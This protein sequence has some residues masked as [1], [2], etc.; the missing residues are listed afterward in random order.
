MRTAALILA[1][2]LLAAAPA[3]AQNAAQPER[4]VPQT[5][6]NSGGP[7]GRMTAPDGSASTG[8]VGR[9]A[10]GTGGAVES[11]KGG[12]ANQNN[13]PVPNT[14]TTSGGPAR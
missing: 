1:G 11:A 9:P 13:Q 8:T 4:A 10:G 12:N 5:G 3:L 14:G 7:S 2:T 6:Q